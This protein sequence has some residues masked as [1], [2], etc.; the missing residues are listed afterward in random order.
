MAEA[1]A[2]RFR[3][4]PT[5]REG[6]AAMLAAIERARHSVALEVYILQAS[7][8]GERFRAAL[9][10]AAARGVRVRV[11]VDAFGSLELPADYLQPV[12]EAGGDCRWFNPLELRRLPYRDHRKVLVVDEEVA[13][14]TGFNIGR[15]YDGD[16]VEHGWRDVGVEV[17]GAFVSVLSQA[18]HGMFGAASF[19]HRRL[20]RFRRHLVPQRLTLEDGDLFLLS[21]GRGRNPARDALVEDIRRSRRVRLTT[22]YLLPPRVL[23][24]AMMAAARGGAQ[25]QLVVPGRSDVILA[26]FAARGQY[27]RL[28]R[29][30]V[31]IYEYQPAVLH[32]KRYLLDDVVY[33]GSANL[34][35]RSLNI[36]Y[37]VL[38]RLRDRA[39]AAAGHAQFEED[40]A[41]SQRIAPETWRRRPWWR[42]VAEWV[43]GLVLGRLDLRLAMRQ[44]NRI[45]ARARDRTGTRVGMSGGRWRSVRS[46][47][48]RVR[49]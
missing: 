45:R 15:D 47:A 39:F 37:E 32:A 10:S 1:D 27:A 12:K 49:R 40:L 18:F 22:A 36:N 2:P 33:V 7:E 6:L 3:W 38:I 20:S 31:E 34:D 4:L 25:V 44:L 23:R 9:R 14:V 46:R 5:G 8:I 48:L 43:A 19:R 41:H 11:L 21:P 26:Q 24:R 16:G 30:G 29:A 17:R 42:R 13:Y 35:L 28:L